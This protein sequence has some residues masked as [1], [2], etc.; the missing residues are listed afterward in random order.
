MA[1]DQIPGRSLH[2][3]LIVHACA[4]QLPGSESEQGT[5]NT[6]NGKKVVVGGNKIISHICLQNFKSVMGAGHIPAPMTSAFFSS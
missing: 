2:F 3:K 5:N 1:L 4:S 6:E